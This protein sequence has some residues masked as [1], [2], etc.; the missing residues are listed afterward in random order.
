MLKGIRRV[1]NG[2]WFEK[3][4]SGPLGLLRLVIGFLATVSG[5]QLW[6]D[7][8]AWFSERGLFPT[9]ISDTWNSLAAPGPRPLNFLHTF[10]SDW[11]ITFFMA[12]FIA[13]ALL[14]T[15]GLWSRVS[16]LI[17]Y[18][19]L[20]MI[21]DRNAAVNTA[22]SDCVLICM[23]F[24]LLLAP[25]GASCSVDRLF[26]ILRGAEDDEAPRVAPWPLRLAQIQVAIVYAVT[27]SSKLLGEQWRN[28][29]AAYYPMS[30]P[31]LSRFPVPLMDANHLWFVHFV[32][33]SA[34]AIEVAL[35]LLVWIPAL[36]LPV[37]AGGVLLHLGIEY[38]LN[39]PL[40]SFLM[41]ASYLS[42]IEQSDLEAF[43]VWLPRAIRLTRLRILFDGECEFC[44]SVLLILQFCDAFR[45]IEFLDYHQP[46]Q[47]AQTGG[48]AFSDAEKSAIAVDERGRRYPGYYAFR[49]AAL[50]I[51][52]L[53]PFVPLLYIPG[54]PLLG[55]TAYK[56]VTENRSH[57]P[58]ARRYRKKAEDEEAPHDG[59]ATQH[60]TLR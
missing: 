54:V 55:E 3:V 25:S 42:F 51:P 8:L 27:A 46:Q 40:F 33:Y 45:R 56:W 24:L 9:S 5:L 16:T 26:R 34:L 48:I 47:L 41:I 36:R 6:P 35:A 1:W 52:V 57:L 23:V 31:E 59:S 49:Q 39:L 18:I 58:V 53:L 11:F 19:G 29:V 15:V 37:L 12:V 14:M 20:N 43:R 10:H 21:H 7:R 50:R 30:L 28:G 17:V 22:G 13:A 2:F 60:K 4:A 38:S 44:R 32:T